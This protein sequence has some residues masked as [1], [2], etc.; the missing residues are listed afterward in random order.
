MKKQYF[1]SCQNLDV[2]IG[3]DNESDRNEMALAR[4]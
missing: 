1:V 4:L 2:L 3:F